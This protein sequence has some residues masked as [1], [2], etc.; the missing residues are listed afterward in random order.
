MTYILVNSY[1]LAYYTQPQ[2]LNRQNVSARKPSSVFVSDE[3]LRAETFYLFKDCG[4]V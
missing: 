3:D 4:C 1:C 2:S